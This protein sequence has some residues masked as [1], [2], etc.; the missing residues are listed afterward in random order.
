[1]KAL[2]NWVCSANK[3]PYLKYSFDELLKKASDLKATETGKADLIKEELTY[4]KRLKCKSSD[5]TL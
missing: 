2:W 4:R 5:F 3:R 1:M